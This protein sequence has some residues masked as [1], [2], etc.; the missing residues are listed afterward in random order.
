[1]VGRGCVKNCNRPRQKA[2]GER[3]S[4]THPKKMRKSCITPLPISTSIKKFPSRVVYT[5]FPYPIKLQSHWQLPGILSPVR[6]QA[7]VIS[8]GNLLSIVA[9]S[10]SGAPAMAPRSPRRG[11][12]VHSERPLRLQTKCGLVVPLCR[13]LWAGCPG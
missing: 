7:S 9:I 5:C 3:Q 6:C 1:M 11:V 10:L 13:G 8:S 2:R 4:P 12:G